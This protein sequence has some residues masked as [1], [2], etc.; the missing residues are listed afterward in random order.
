MAFR[1]APRQGWH[2]L[3]NGALVL[4]SIAIFVMA[5][6]TGPSL[7][8]AETPVTGFAHIDLALERVEREPLARQITVYHRSAIALAQVGSPA[9]ADLARRMEDAVTAMAINDVEKLVELASLWNSLAVF[10]EAYIAGS[11]RVLRRVLELRPRELT[12]RETGELHVRLLATQLAN[13]DSEEATTRRILDSLY[14]I[15]DDSI[16]AR[17]LVRAAEIIRDTQDRLNLNPVV[18]QGIAIVPALEDAT[19]AAI[20]SMRLADLSASLDRPRDVRALREAA[21]RNAEGGLLIQ[22][23]RITELQRLVEIAFHQ[24]NQMGAEIILQNVAPVSARALGYGFLA[25]QMLLRGSVEE[26][27]DMYRQALTIAMAIDDPTSRGRTVSN[28]IFDRLLHDERWSPVNAIADLLGTTPVAT[29]NREDRI[30]VL[31]NLFAGY[32]ARNEEQQI[33]RLRGLIRSADEL[34]FI[35]IAAAESL[36]GAGRGGVAEIPL[37]QLER[38]PQPEPGSRQT[39]ALRVALLWLALGDPDRAVIIANEADPGEQA[40]LLS[41]I[42]ADFTFNPVARDVLERMREG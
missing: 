29:F 1:S 20:L 36:V 25:R 38:I 23:P 14:L 32:Y 42:P 12:A 35:R 13:P 28:L 31:G 11:H 18:Q 7:A 27:Q 16:R 17:Y 33:V 21:V 40:E 9:A 22:P 2:L 6:S 8:G 30:F 19:D 24:G 39:P 37:R 4:L 5:C 15:P 41:G 10:D 26:G 34:S 3:V